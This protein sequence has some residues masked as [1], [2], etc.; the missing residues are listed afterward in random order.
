MTTPDVPRWPLEPSD[1][2][3]SRWL[4]LVGDAVRAELAGLSRAPACGSVGATGLA[5]A[6]QVSVPIPEDPIE[7]GLPAVLQRVLAASKASLGTP[8]PGYLAYVPG[9]GLPMARG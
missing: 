2:E 1:A 7:G 9:G 6:E 8:M 3:F 4:A 5:I